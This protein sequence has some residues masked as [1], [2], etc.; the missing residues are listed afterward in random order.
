M[1]E[2]G[3]R[4]HNRHG[5]KTGDRAPF[6]G[7]LGPHLTQR[8]WAKA[9]LHV[10]C[11]LDP[12][13]RLAT[14]DMDQKLEA[15]PPFGGVGACF[16]SNTMSLGLRPTSLPSGILIHAAICHNKGRKLGGGSTPFWGEGAVSPS[17]TMWPVLRPTSMP[18][19][20]LIYPAV[21]PQ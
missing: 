2:M 8:R 12:S 5:P 11:H 16:P 1:A 4:G 9:Y 15:P 14:I 17:S 21:W 6:R 7:E 19:G 20:I 18:S 10:K 13:S 3:D